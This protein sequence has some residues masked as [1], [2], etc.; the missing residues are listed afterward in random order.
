MIR[1][2]KLIEFQTGGAEGSTVREAIGS[3]RY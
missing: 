2:T 3:K 1:P